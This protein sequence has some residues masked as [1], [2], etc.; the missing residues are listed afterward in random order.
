MKG[1]TPVNDTASARSSVQRPPFV[2]RLL[3]WAI[4]GVRGLG[5]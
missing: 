3:A 2:V 1:P 4:T 5:G